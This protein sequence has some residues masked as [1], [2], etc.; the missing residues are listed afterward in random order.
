MRNRHV[1]K[2]L[3]G[4]HTPASTTLVRVQVADEDEPPAFLQPRYTFQVPEGSPRGAP[5]GSVSALDPDHRRA[6]V[7]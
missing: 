3:L 6:P 7:R 5:V 2:R 4:H 1:D